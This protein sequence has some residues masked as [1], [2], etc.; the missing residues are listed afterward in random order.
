MSETHKERAERF[1][2]RHCLV[3]DYYKRV[4]VENLALEFEAA[5]KDATVWDVVVKR[6]IWAPAKLG[7][8]DIER[9]ATLKCSICGQGFMRALEN[10]VNRFTTIWLD[11]QGRTLCSNTC[12]NIAV[13]ID[14]ILES[15][16]TGA[17]RP[18]CPLC[19]GRLMRIDDAATEKP[20][21]IECATETCDFKVAIDG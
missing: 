6:A 3:P 16:H 20:K 8:L 18:S 7:P 17:P 19:E 10:N 2:S 12:A 9:H 4:T 5:A 11:R 1:V 13:K 15:H 21:R 14:K